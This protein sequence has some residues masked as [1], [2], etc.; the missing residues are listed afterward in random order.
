MKVYFEGT[1]QPFDKS[2]EEDFR[3]GSGPSS[4]AELVKESN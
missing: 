2:A 1:Y 3:L 4:A